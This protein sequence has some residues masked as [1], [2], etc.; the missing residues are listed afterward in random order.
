MMNKESMPKPV[1]FIRYVVHAAVASYGIMILGEVIEYL[2]GLP[3]GSQNRRL[4]YFFIGPTF[5]FP[6]LAGLILGFIFGARL[7]RS[8]SRL[9]FIFPL[10]IMAWE[11]WVFIHYNDE[12][13]WRNFV[14]NF[15]GTNCTSSEC[16]EEGWITSPLV[17]SLAYSLGAEFGRLKAS[18]A[19][20]RTSCS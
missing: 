1:V 2:I 5:L 4:D 15:L 12:V 13:T 3:L 6:I 11:V 9:L 20:S 7:P 8:S 18:F 10:A 19:A 17:S 16:L 14:N